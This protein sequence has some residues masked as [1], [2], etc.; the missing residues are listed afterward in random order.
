MWMNQNEDGDSAVYRFPTEDMSPLPVSMAHKEQ[1]WPRDLV[2]WGLAVYQFEKNKPRFIVLRGEWIYSCDYQRVIKFQVLSWQATL[3]AGGQGEGNEDNQIGQC[4][5]IAFDAQDR[6]YVSDSWNNRVNRY[7][8]GDHTEGS[9]TADATLVAG[10]EEKQTNERVLVA[11]TYIQPRGNAILE[12]GSVLMVCRSASRV[13]MW[14]PNPS[15]SPSQYGNKNGFGYH[16][17]V[18]V[19]GANGHG[20]GNHQL[21]RPHGLAAYGNTM[22]IMDTNCN[23]VQEWTIGQ[24]SGT[25]IAGTG[26]KGA[27]DPSISAYKVEPNQIQRGE[28]IIFHRG[29]LYITDAEKDRIVRWGTGLR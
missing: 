29:W 12:D 11:G 5:A 17:G 25:K 18:V 13:I 23:R 10:P 1:L 7:Q 20:C 15:L 16:K 26:T 14:K 4:E 27:W 9:G 2:G 24:T 8:E 28:I 22:Y 3:V 6:F 21:N 19:A